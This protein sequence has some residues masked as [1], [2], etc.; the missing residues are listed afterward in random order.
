[1][2]FKSGGCAVSDRLPGHGDAL[3]GRKAQRIERRGVE[4]TDELSRDPGFQ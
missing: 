4:L 3:L 2:P 1:M